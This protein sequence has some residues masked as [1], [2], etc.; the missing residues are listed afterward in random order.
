MRVEE[1]GKDEGYAGEREVARRCIGV[2]W[3][4]SR[5]RRG[6]LWPETRLPRENTIEPGYNVVLQRQ[7]G[8]LSNRGLYFEPRWILSSLPG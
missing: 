1:R 3:H 7:T 4:D 2:K 5:Q 8:G 6:L